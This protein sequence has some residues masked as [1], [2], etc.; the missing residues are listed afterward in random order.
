MKRLF[1]AVIP[2]VCFIILIIPVLAFAE[3][4]DCHHGDSTCFIDDSGVVYCKG[5]LVSYPADLELSS[6][7]VDSRATQIGS[8]AFSGN[9]HVTSVTLQEGI[10]MIQDFAFEG[11]TS[12]TTVHFPET[13][14]IIDDY[15]FALCNSLEDIKLPHSLYCIGFQAFADTWAMRTIELPASL[16]FIGDEAFAN[17]HLREVLVYSINITFG[18]NV[19]MPEHMEPDANLLIHFLKE[20]ETDEV[21]NVIPWCEAQAKNDKIRIMF[22]LVDPE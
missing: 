7:V 11:C 9:K 18:Y 19:F 6:Y 1:I 10:V 13:L 22:D 21:G 14:L 5:I 2:A 20:V 8:G 3:C 15:A 12:L 16:R 17:S 4:P